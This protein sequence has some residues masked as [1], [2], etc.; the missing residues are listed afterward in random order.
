M[1]PEIKMDSMMAQML[2]QLGKEQKAEDNGQV[3]PDMP[4]MSKLINQVTQSLF[5]NPQMQNL[6][7]SGGSQ[8]NSISHVQSNKPKLLVHK[9]IVT[10]AELYNGCERSGGGKT[11]EIVVR[12]GEWRVQCGCTTTPQRRISDILKLQL[13]NA[14]QERAATDVRASLTLAGNECTSACQMYYAM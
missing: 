7:K 12:I 9:L 4:D 3:P 11:S 14:K 2:S 6:L 13:T 1:L 10:L 5:S 8:G